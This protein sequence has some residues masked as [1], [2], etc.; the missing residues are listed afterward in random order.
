MPRR[1]ANPQT[2][3]KAVYLSILKA[4]RS[5]CDTAERQR[6]RTKF[7]LIEYFLVGLKKHSPA[8]LC[9]QLGLPGG[10]RIHTEI[11]KKKNAAIAR[12]EGGKHRDHVYV[13]NIP[14]R[15]GEKFWGGSQEALTLA[16]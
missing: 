1:K 4:K 11:V 2:T 8:M 12:R 14:I 7:M 9:S 5:D 15:I 3:P 13:S 6:S 16:R 10:R